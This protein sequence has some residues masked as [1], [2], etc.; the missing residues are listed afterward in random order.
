[1]KNLKTIERP[2]VVV[3]VGH[4][5]H[6]K[7]TLLDF[8]RKSNV[9][10]G[11]AGGITQHVSAYEITHKTKAGANKKIT[12]IDTPGHE[13][14]SAMRET[15]SKIADVAILV[16]SAEDGVKAQTEEAIRVITE[17]KIP[18]VV[19]INKIDKEN[20]NAQRTRQD[21]AEK[22]VLVEDYGG[23]IPVAEISAK[24]GKGISELLDLV[25]LVAELED[26]KADSNAQATGLV[27]EAH[28][29]PKI[30]N[31]ATLII[32][33]GTI[34]NGDYLV[35]GDQAFRI[36]R[37]NNFLGEQIKEATVSAPVEIFG[38]EKLPEVGANF[39]AFGDK[40]EAENFLKDQK[41][42]PKLIR[43]AHIAN[44]IPQAEGEIK[45]VIIPIGIK[46][47]VLGTL[48]AIEREVKKLGTPLVHL[49]VIVKGVGK[50]TENDVKLVSSGRDA[51]MIGFNVTADS[52]AKELAEKFGI[53]IQ[54][55]DIIY[56]LSEWLTEEIVKRTPKI[57]TEEIL[58]KI[59]VLK[60]FSVNKDKQVLGGTVLSGS[61][62]L[63]KQFRVIR[64][65]S[66][67]SRGKVLE[68]ETQK[69]K[70]KEVEKD[71]MFGSLVD[72]KIAIAPGDVLEVFDLVEK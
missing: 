55:F 65:D 42:T 11:E 57:I 29:N 52:S 43:V 5:D 62:I 18:Y 16:V 15:S 10:A 12:F 32:K 14:F 61:M 28:M 2:P 69:I 3:V 25:L 19:A 13:A 44:T 38:L 66:V 1:M 24:S 67:L 58:G 21:L 17:K 22:N 34:A 60:I 48:S 9:V 68:L 23:N 20:A 46:T 64:R 8:I 36:K 71:K 59:K 53:N 63:G 72:S 49:E 26:L 33:N 7:S 30:G 70:V 40:K 47:D 45:Q 37:M 31:I 35:I 4:I 56:K 27:L 6:G 51:I 39:F 50:I 54:T 41:I